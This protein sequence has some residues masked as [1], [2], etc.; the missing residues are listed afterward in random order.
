MNNIKNKSGKMG[1]GAKVFLWLVGI[2]LVS[3]VAMSLFGGSQQ[4]LPTGGAEGSTDNCPSD[5]SWSGTID[6]RNSLNISGAETYD[7]T[8]YFYFAGTDDLKVSITDTTA[9]AVTLTCGESYDVKILST[10]GATGD[11]AKIVGISQ[12]TVDPSGESAT[13]KAT[14]NGNRI[15]ISSQ[16]H[17]VSEVQVY[18][19]IDKAFFRSAID[20]TAYNS[21]DGVSW[22][23]TGSQADSYAIGSGGELDVSVSLRSTTS[24]ENLNDLGLYLL[25][26]A[27]TT[28]YDTPVM[29]LNGAAMTDVKDSGLTP[30][31]TL[32]YSAYEYIFLIPSSTDVILNDKVTLDFD[33]FALSGVNPGA[34][35]NIEFDIAPVGS[36]V[37]IGN[38]K[39]SVL[40][41]GSVQDDTSQ[42][43]VF[44]LFDMIFN[45]S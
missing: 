1:P 34:S 5:L 3:V 13:F 24:D 19:N 37:S 39:A 18:S 43:V 41:F 33:I 30:S 17:G 32:A 23:N 14:G 10:S 21:T 9:G 26:D 44:T 11:S 31:E 20:T 2:I 15:T 35:D 6:V 36:Y 22:N 28:V 16:Q 45:I 29:R 12:G 7:T 25:I 27:A 4:Q 8:A 42:T 40:A 38:P